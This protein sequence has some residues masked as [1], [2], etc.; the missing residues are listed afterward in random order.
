MSAANA[1]LQSM[2]KHYTLVFGGSSLLALAAASCGYVEASDFA[3]RT[4][5]PFPTA[6]SSPKDTTVPACLSSSYN[7]SFATEYFTDP[8]FTPVPGSCPER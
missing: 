8:S 4:A 2:I 7:S 6:P 5:S 1:D 3:P